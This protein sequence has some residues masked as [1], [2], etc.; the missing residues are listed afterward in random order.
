MEKFKTLDAFYAHQ[1]GDTK[2]QVD[3]LRQVILSAEPRL[4]ETLKWN[5]PNFVF[6]GE[7]RLTVNVM[8]K[9]G[10]VKLIFHMGA[11]K[12]EDKKALPVMADTTGL[13]V[14]NSDIRGTITFDSLQHVHQVREQLTA[15]VHD[16]LR[17]SV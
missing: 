2:A 3:A 13:I 5:A 7:D 9:E 14:W 17:I 15:L 11:V 10:K 16:W 8:N 4:A 1:T 6:E 12:K